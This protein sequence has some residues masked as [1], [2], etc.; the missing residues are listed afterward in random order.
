MLAHS[1]PTYCTP[2]WLHSSVGLDWIVVVCMYV[3]ISEAG[4]TYIEGRGY[5]LLSLAT[6]ILVTF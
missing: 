3:C 5:V 4:G 1:L 2:I 6:F